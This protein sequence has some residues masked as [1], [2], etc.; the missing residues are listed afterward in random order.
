MLLLLLQIPHQQILNTLIWMFLLIHMFDLKY[1]LLLFLVLLITRN[2][3]IL[4][5]HDK[6]NKI[7]RHRMHLQG[8]FY[9]KGQLLKYALLYYSLHP[10]RNHLYFEI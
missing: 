5:L 8:Q 3:F 9:F 2:F 10:L 4:E 1:L 7:I 6:L